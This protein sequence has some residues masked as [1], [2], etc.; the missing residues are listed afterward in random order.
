[1]QTW[2]VALPMYNIGATL[3]ADYERF[4]IAV[5]AALQAR[6]W[7]EEIEIVHQIDDLE[8]F[9]LRSDLLFSQ[10]CGYPLTTSLRGRVRLLGT[11]VYNVAGCHGFYYRSLIV[12]NEAYGHR[13]PDKPLR[14]LADFRGCSGAVNQSTSHS[15]MNAL[16]HTVAPFA[17]A[18]QFFDKVRLSG[19]HLESLAMLQRSEAD[20]A[21]ID[22]VTFAHIAH[23]FPEKITGL[24]VLQESL[25]APGLPFIA[26]LQLNQAQ[27]AMVM[28]AL[29]AVCKNDQIVAPLRLVGLARTRVEDY[30]AITAME[31]FAV[32]LNYPRIA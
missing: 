15:G 19:S 4:L 24:R 21:A 31:E 18:G 28:E 11:P 10:A 6:G 29:E 8:R 17:R 12:T 3:A 9:W 2:K 5:I 25:A 27:S 30:Q 23:Y 13:N 22:C 1:M 7:R 20:L 32:A 14:A 16:R 26:S